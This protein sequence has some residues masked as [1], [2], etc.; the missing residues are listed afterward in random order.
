MKLKINLKNNPTGEDGKITHPSNKG[1]AGYDLY[2]SSGPMTNGSVVI[3]DFYRNISYI[4]YDTNISLDIQQEKDEYSFFALLFP[5]SSISKYNLIMSNSVGVI[6]SGYQ[7]TIKVR[8]KYV[9]QPEDIYLLEEKENDS[10]KYPTVKVNE[11]K[12]YKKGDKIAQLI[13][14]KHEHP[15]FLDHEILKENQ[16]ERGLGGFGSSGE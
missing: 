3:S 12:I 4:E 11:D 13:F 9:I 5:R 6:D 15:D 14:S 7:D 10:V 16:K 1:D 8:F 2:A